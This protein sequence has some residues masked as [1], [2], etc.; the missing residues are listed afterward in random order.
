MAGNASIAY[1]YMDAVH[2]D[3]IQ[4]ETNSTSTLNNSL[5]K[6]RGEFIPFIAS[7]SELTSLFIYNIK[8][9]VKDIDQFRIYYNNE[10]PYYSI[11]DRTSWDEFSENIICYRGDCYYNTVTLKFNWNFIDPE[12]PGITQIADPNTW[13]KNF[14]IKDHKSAKTDDTE[15]SEVRTVLENFILNND[16]EV[17]TPG[18]KGYDKALTKSSM[19]YGANNIN[20]ID[21]NAVELG[22]YI[23]FPICSNVNLALRDEDISRS[24]EKIIFGSNRGFYPLVKN[25]LPEATVIN[26]GLHKNVGDRLYFKIPDVPYIK[27]IFPTRIH[28]SEYYVNGLFKNGNRVFPI[29]NYKDYTLEYGA[30]VKLIEWYGN[31]IAVMEHGVLLITV[32]ERVQSVNAQGQSVSI[33]SD[34]VLPRTPQVLSNKFG[35]V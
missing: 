17:L 11:S 8:E 5:T 25:R 19:S 35:S 15:T 24:D 13:S 14:R 32:N 2:G 33:N 34:Q 18:E 16:D 27:D 10:S 1:K 23:T 7:S 29:Q 28:Y 22:V 31:L 20:R 21:V 9:N 12:L 4:S 3:P 30:I 26:R 6:I